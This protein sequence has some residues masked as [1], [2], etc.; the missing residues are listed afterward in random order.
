MKF[1]K[2][3]WMAGFREKCQNDVLHG[4]VILWCYDNVTHY[5]LTSPYR[6]SVYVTSSLQLFHALWFWQVSAWRLHYLKSSLMTS[7]QHLFGR[8]QLLFPSTSKSKIF[9]VFSSLRFT[10]PNQHSLLHLNIEFRLSVSIY[11]GENLC[12]N[13]VLSWCCTTITALLFHYSPNVSYLLVWEPKILMSRV[14][15]LWHSC[16][17]FDHVCLKKL[18]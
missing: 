18:L 1:S 11:L 9:P 8:P 14:S 13:V 5:P 10:C 15:S 3:T 4:N 17:T 7:N 2:Q 16:Y 6:S 12:W